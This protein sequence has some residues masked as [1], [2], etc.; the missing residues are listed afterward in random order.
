MEVAPNNETIIAQSLGRSPEVQIGAVDGGWRLARWRRFLGDYDVPALPDP[1]FV[2]HI[3][4]KR[5]LRARTG[6]RLSEISSMP[7]L[8][9]IVPPGMATSWRVDGELDVVTLSIAGKDLEAAPGRGQFERM[10]F[11]FSDPLGVALTR[12]ILAELYTPQSAARDAYLS[13]L[14]EALKA[15]ALR[16][17]LAANSTSFPTSDHSA[18]RIHQVMNAVQAR[19]EVDHTLDSLAAQAGLSP[20]HF[21]RMFRRATGVS[22]HQYVLRARLERAQTLLAS[23][24]L[25]IAQVAGALGFATQSHFTRAFRNYC[26]QTPSLWR[27]AHSP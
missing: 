19:P 20:S 11:A 10:R 2:V 25:S 23:R 5:H 3:G 8:A 26:G 18:Y 24:E 6:G 1:M 16:G 15:H 9:T 22:P 12:Q 13:A 27:R 17:P 7:G 21:S 14:V 4:G